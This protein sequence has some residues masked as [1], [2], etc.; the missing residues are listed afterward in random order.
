MFSS[1]DYVP[2]LFFSHLTIE[3]LLKAHW[4][5]DN[6]GNHPPRIHNLVILSSQIKLKLNESDIDFLNQMNQFQIEG[7]YPDYKLTLQKRYKQK[8]TK[9]ILTQINSLRKCLIKNL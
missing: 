4:V 8:Q 1:K 5:K 9:E 6:T 3:K 7:R 2:A